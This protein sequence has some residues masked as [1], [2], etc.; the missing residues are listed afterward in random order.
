MK[1][2]QTDCNY[3]SKYFRNSGIS[4]ALGGDYKGAIKDFD[5]ALKI[6][7][8]DLGSLIG[9]GYAKDQLGYKEKAKEDFSKAGE[10]GLKL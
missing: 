8:K 6:D 3:N 10:I 1:I 5:K 2:L 9:R 7:C 4:K